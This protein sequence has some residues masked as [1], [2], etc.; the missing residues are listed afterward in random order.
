VEAVCADLL[1]A[2]RSLGVVLPVL[3]G[4]AR[5]E[6]GGLRGGLPTSQRGLCCD[7]WPPPSYA[8]PTGE[9]VVGFHPETDGHCAPAEDIARLA[10]WLGAAQKLLGATR[11]LLNQVP[12][13]T[14]AAVDGR[15][16]TDGRSAEEH[17]QRRYVRVLSDAHC[18]IA[19]DHDAE[20]RFGPGQLRRGL[21]DRHRKAFARWVAAHG[22]PW[23]DSGSLLVR[24]QAETFG[25]VAREKDGVSPYK[26]LR[27]VA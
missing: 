26:T 1:R 19:Q 22:L 7:G 10:T 6:V 3:V 27:Q 11:S 24:W 20:D 18:L 14:L 4:Q 5:L 15:R 13:S 25:D 9:T 16:P 21:C 12:A 17:A 8:D 2:L 23:E